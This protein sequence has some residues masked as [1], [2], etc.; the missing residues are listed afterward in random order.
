[1]SLGIT[2]VNK[3]T[4]AHVLG[5]KSSKG[6]DVVGDAAVI[7]ADDLAQILGVEASRQRRRTDQIAEHHSQLALF[8]VNG[9]WSR[10]GRGLGYGRRRFPAQVGDRPQQSAP[11][12]D[13]ADAEF[14]Q[15]FS[16]QVA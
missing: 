11:M 16:S 4:V 1:V 6:R 7:G 13:Q 15:V 8:C 3:H 2:E 12:A 5:D 14:P 10:L 9:D